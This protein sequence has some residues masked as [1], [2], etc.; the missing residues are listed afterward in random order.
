MV[1]LLPEQG[2]ERESMSR[3]GDVASLRRRV[4]WSLLSA[5]R[6]F[7]AVLGFLVEK[8]PTKRV[9]DI[10][11]MDVVVVEWQGNRES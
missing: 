4:W 11:M 2:G 10:G 1:F 6:C 5:E 7:Q 8:N 3:R 9:H